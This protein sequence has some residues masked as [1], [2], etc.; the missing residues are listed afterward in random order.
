[1]ACVMA[2][3]WASVNV[4]VQRRAAVS[5]GAEADQLVGVTQ[6]GATLEILPFE[7]GQIHQHVFRCGLAREGRDRHGTLPFIDC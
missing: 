6:V 5:A 7:P 3:M 4:L 1:M 2:R